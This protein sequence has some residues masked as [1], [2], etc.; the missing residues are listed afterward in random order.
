LQAGL[1]DVSGYHW[2]PDHHGRSAHKQVDIRTLPGFGELAAKVIQDGRS[3]L[4]YDRLY[5]LYQ[6]LAH[7]RQ[8]ADRRRSHIDLGEIGVFQG[9]TSWFLASAAK[10]LGLEGVSLHCFDTFEG[11]DPRDIQP[12]VDTVQRPGLFG[13]TSLGSVRAYLREFENVTCYAGRFQETC[14][15][16]KSRAFHF[17]HLD[18][19][20]FE[21]TRFALDFFDERLVVGGAMVVDDYGFTSCVGVRRAVDEFVA[22]GK[23]YFAIE[24]PT[25]QY[26]LTKHTT[27]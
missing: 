26:L 22:S 16:V 21:P 11:H 1:R 25:G 23:P 13:E 24:L 18:M 8:L 19:D 10:A 20:I 27:E 3:Q 2:V 5:V 7:V 4:Y 6:A 9:G 14:E 17:A 12:A 15:L